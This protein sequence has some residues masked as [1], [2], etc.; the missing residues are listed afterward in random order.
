MVPS[1]SQ[2]YD[3]TC[4]WIL[5]VKLCCWWIIPVILI[6]SLLLQAFIML[7]NMYN[8]V[9]MFFN[10]DISGELIRYKLMKY[11][12]SAVSLIF[13]YKSL[14]Y[15]TS[16]SAKFQMKERIWISNILKTLM[17]MQQFLNLFTFYPDCTVYIFISL[18][19]KQRTMI[20]N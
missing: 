20:N 13:G 2:T 6:V 4:L 15:W 9:C 17:L 16:K 1:L 8:N 11:S 7:T 5:Q 18:R 12:G 3:H 14:L 10:W 19:G